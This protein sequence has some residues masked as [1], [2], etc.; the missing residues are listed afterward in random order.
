MN[1]VTFRSRK[2]RKAKPAVITL[3]NWDK[4]AEG[5]ANQPRMR[6]EPATFEDPHTGREQPTG[7]KR[8]RRQSW[9]QIYARKG[10]LSRTQLLAAERLARAAE[11][12]PDRDPLAAVLSP[13]GT[14][15]FD[16]QAARVD[17]RAEFRRLWADVP[18]ASQPVMQ[19]VVL[20]DEAIWSGC[21]A[22]AWDRHM[23]RLRDG[24]NAIA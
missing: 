12:Y 18:S 3:P 14:D 19:R 16:P 9:V 15:G 1:A 13:K 8:R 21:G 4:G 17:A 22:V 6:V 5:P 7:G 20:G 11:G 10:E 24:L 23:Q 2:G